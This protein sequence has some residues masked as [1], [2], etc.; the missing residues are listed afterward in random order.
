M[1]D[2]NE[3]PARNCVGCGTPLPVYTKRIRCAA[4]R[5]RAERAPRSGEK[6]RAW[7]RWRQRAKE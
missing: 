7:R 1:H 2:D 3:D 6:I 4:C 5:T